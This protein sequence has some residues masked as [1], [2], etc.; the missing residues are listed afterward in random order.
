MDWMIKKGQRGKKGAK[1][2]TNSGKQVHRRVSASLSR[3]SR[4]EGGKNEPDETQ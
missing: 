2:W 1:A 3:P 4:K